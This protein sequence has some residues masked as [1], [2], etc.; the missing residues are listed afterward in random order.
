[1]DLL[2][3]YPGAWKKTKTNRR[4]VF[5]CTVQAFLNRS[6]P[7]RL[8]VDLPWT[9][10]CIE[11][12]VA[13]KFKVCLSDPRQVITIEYNIIDLYFIWLLKIFNLDLNGG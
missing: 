7:V 5:L 6:R 8:P 10:G 9:G 1:M 13:F 11:A 4:Q 3:D 2:R 12:G